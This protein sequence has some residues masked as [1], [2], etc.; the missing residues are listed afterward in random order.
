VANKPAQNLGEGQRHQPVLGGMSATVMMGG[1]K[2][3]GHPPDPA[4][5]LA[6]RSL[7]A[8][9]NRPFD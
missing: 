9:L 6:T 1:G 8:L 7:A 5:P 4:C 2:D 3:F